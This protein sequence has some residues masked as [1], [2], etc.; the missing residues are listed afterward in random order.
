[1]NATDQ[2][3]PDFEKY[4]ELLYITAQLDVDPFLDNRLD[5]SGVVQ[6]TLLEAHLGFAAFRGTNEGDLLA[7]LRRILANNLIDQIRRITR[8]RPS[9][10]LEQSVSATSLKLQSLLAADHTPPEERAIRNEEHLRLTQALAK[11]PADQ[12]TAVLR[13]HLQSASLASVAEEMGRSRE[14]VAG[15][16]HRGMTSLRNLLQERRD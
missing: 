6:Q 14:A 11:L 1:M 12:R 3:L 4:R 5:L 10:R 9:A 7:W 8:G 2:A 15:L 16:I 13:H